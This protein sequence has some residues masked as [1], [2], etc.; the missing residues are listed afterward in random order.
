MILAMHSTLS[1]RT[2]SLLA[3]LVSNLTISAPP[4]VIHWGPPQEGIT[5]GIA[6]I[7][8]FGKN[9]SIAIYARPTTNYANNLVVPEARQAFQVSLRDSSGNLCE[10]KPGGTRFGVQLQTVMSRGDRIR[11]ELRFLDEDGWPLGGPRIDECFLVKET[12]DYE[13]EI[14]V[15]MLKETA[16]KLIPVVLAPMQMKLHLVANT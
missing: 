15:R 14:R 5:V 13:V 10:P 11:R 2:S 1:I 12:K 3:L 4:P 6:L 8:G 7:E 16:D 9:G